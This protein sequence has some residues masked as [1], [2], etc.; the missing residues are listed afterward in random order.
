[1][2]Q[3]KEIS[4]FWCDY[5]FIV[6]NGEKEYFS[7]NRQ[8]K[9]VEHC[10]K[11]KHMRNYLSENNKI[12]CNYCVEEMTEE[13]YEL[14]KKRNQRLWTMKTAINPYLKCN[15]FQWSK[16][17]RR[18]E[19]FDAMILNKQS[20]DNTERKK[21]N[22]Q[23]SGYVNTF[24]FLKSN[25]NK[26]IEQKEK[27]MEHQLREEEK[28]ANKPDLE[29][30][31]ECSTNSKKLYYNPD[32]EYSGKHLSLF[33]MEDCGCREISEGESEQTN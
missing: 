20:I 11:K 7:C 6:K 18:F 33:E 17:H 15:K 2:P 4:K 26:T 32:D 19:S 27:E 21:P 3:V 10:K 24:S 28:Y 16:N 23:K 29:L 30:C 22:L 25:E 5:C 12:V 14:H 9:F 8:M 31:V 1:M 13:A